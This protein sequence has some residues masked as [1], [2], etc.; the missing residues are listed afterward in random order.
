VTT[1]SSTAL[2]AIVSVSSTPV[3]LTC[4]KDKAPE[5]VIVGDVRLETLPELVSRNG[6]VESREQAQARGVLPNWLQA[7]GTLRLRNSR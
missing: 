6:D 2:S 1:V 7:I 4:S 3:R 5:L